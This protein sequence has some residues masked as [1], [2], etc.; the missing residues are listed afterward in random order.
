MNSDALRDALIAAGASALLFTAVK[1][2]RRRAH[3][4][5]STTDALADAGTIAIIVF[6]V[7][8]T[9]PMW[10]MGGDEILPPPFMPV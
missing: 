2:L 8:F 9:L 1:A 3:G 4:D 6:V 10:Q 7:V 5:T